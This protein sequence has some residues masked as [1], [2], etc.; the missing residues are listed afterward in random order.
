[1]KAVR[2]SNADANSLKYLEALEG[3][4]GTSE[5]AEDLYFVF[6]LLRQDPGETL[7]D[8]LMRLEKALTK[9]VK[10]GRLSSR[11]SVDKARVE[12]LIR[13]AVESDLLLLQLRR[14]DPPDFLALL[15]EIR[16]EEESEA[17]RHSLG[18]TAKPVPRPRQKMTNFAVRELQAEIQDLRM[19][20]AESPSKVPVA[21]AESREVM[22]KRENDLSPEVLALKK[23]VQRL[24]SS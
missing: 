8:F 2:F 22:I 18:V 1:M 16:E 12:Q 6:R 14:E 13:G 4:F 19:Q 3:A 11:G 21:E 5:S 7:S 15:N 20:V 10:K 24:G 23:Q 9:V 17:A